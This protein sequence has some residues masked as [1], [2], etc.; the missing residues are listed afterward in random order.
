MPDWT[1]G[2]LSDVTYPWQF[3]RQTSPTW[4]ALATLLAGHR[5]PR[6]DAPFR[7]CDLGCGQG[8]TAL[9]VAACHPSAEI[10]GFDFNPSHIENATRMA[11]A[12]GLANARFAETS[13][14]ALATAPLGRYPQMDFIILHGVWTW[15]S[16]T[17][18]AN[19]VTFIRNHLAPGGIVYIAYNALAGWAAMLPVQRCMRLLSEIEPAPGDAAALRGMEFMRELM[20]A[21]GEFF[22]RNPVVA[23]RLAFLA[24]QD[25]HYLS[26]ELL[27][28]SWDPTPFDAVARD[29]DG[30]KCS[31]IGSATLLE[32]L[33]AFSVP[34][35]MAPILARTQDP[36]LREAIRDFGAARM[37]RRD[38]YRR[39]TEKPVPG[40]LM[41]LFDA[42][43][44][45]D[46]GREDTGEI[47]IQTWGDQGVGLRTD[48]YD[49]LRRRLRSGPLA[50]AD[51]RRAVGDFALAREALAVLVAT[52]IAHPL[53]AS[54]DEARPTTHALNRVIAEHNRW[55][56]DIPFQLSPNFGT[57]LMADALETMI[58]QEYSE[59]SGATVDRL[60]GMFLES[61]RTLFQDGKAITDPG[62]ARA[63]WRQI[64]EN[65]ATRRAPLFRHAGILREEAAF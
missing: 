3:Y 6:L 29:M 52:D 10:Y 28:A 56:G 21:Q 34:P 18:R 45:G 57:A 53:R 8:F 64:V 9:G 43:V 50:G 20:A 33:D 17:Q 49:P 41:A 22:T 47:K 46:L 31:F 1:D 23:N 37:F 27:H 12:A 26:H 36:R 15:V 30:A 38:L 40:E 7:W 55:G 63:G 60:M 35:S 59:Q 4:L 54:G 13:F 16:S 51:L 2:Y 5:P 14:E 44:L 32:N 25:A 19:L 61:G 11:A 62:L 39:G 65:F 42:L 24:Q 58:V 48:V